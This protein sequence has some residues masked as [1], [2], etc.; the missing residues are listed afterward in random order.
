MFFPD[1]G[2]AVALRGDRVLCTVMFE[3]K[4]ERNEKVQVPVVFTLNGRK[5]IIRDDEEPEIYIDWDINKP[6]YP[7]VSMNYGS[8]VVAKVKWGGGGG[9]LVGGRWMLP[10]RRTFEESL[11]TESHRPTQCSKD[12]L[13]QNCST[14]HVN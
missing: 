6:L 4:R 2:P 11:A 14:M 12:F 5:I 7:Y 3:K 9:M 1:P 8:S 10:Q 13:D